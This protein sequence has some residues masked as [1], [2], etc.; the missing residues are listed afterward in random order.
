MLLWSQVGEADDGAGGKIYINQYEAKICERENECAYATSMSTPKIPVVINEYAKNTF[1]SARG[2][3]VQLNRPL[4]NLAPEQ[5]PRNKG[6]G[7]SLLELLLLW[8]F[9]LAVTCS[10]VLKGGY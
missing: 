2:Y 4:L 1:G 9:I 5:Y 7:K 8:C 10:V 3:K 6:L